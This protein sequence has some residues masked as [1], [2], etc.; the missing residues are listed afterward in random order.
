MSVP[1]TG[2]FPSPVKIGIEEIIIGPSGRR[3][4]PVILLFVSGCSKVRL[5]LSSNLIMLSGMGFIF[6]SFEYNHRCEKGAILSSTIHFE[7]FKESWNF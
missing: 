6:F 4:I 3:I 2:P 5:P 7:T 1:F